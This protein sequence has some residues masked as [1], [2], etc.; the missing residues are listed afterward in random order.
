MSVSPSFATF[1][2]EQL[3][4]G[5]PGVRGRGMFGG[6]GIYAGEI[7][8]ALVDDDVLYFKVDDSNRSDFEGRG[9]KPFQ[10]YG[11]KGEVMQYY[12]VPEDLLDDADALGVWAA[13]AIAVARK[14]KSRR[15]S[16]R[17]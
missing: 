2:L 14:D 15:R 11:D 12:Q 8:F 7:F 4:R 1:V 3:G 16:R 6:L 5:V 13:A 10:P 17:R 9:M